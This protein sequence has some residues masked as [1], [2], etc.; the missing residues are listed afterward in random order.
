MGANNALKI[1][2]KIKQEAVANLFSAAP[3][4]VNQVLLD[5]MPNAPYPTLPNPVNLARAANYLR[6]K[7]RPTDSTD[8]LFD[9]EEQHIPDGFLR[10]DIKV[11]TPF[12]F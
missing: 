5:E 1:V 6:K 3:A 12:N 8:L 4:I 7:L 2:S 11:S 9:L 10:K